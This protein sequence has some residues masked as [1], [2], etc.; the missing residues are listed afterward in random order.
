MTDLHTLNGFIL[1]E[2][3]KAVAFVATDSPVIDAKPLWI[4]RK[5]I[6]ET[7]ELDTLDKAFQI[8]GNEAQHSGVPVEL[9]IDKA[10][11]EKIK[12]I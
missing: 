12:A 7:V 11:L 9:S 3:D 5:K 10:F 1:R 8:K 2:T 6:A 4:P